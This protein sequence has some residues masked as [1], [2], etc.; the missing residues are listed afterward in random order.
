MNHTHPAPPWIHERLWKDV[1]GPTPSLLP[2]AW[3]TLFTVVLDDTLDRPLRDW[4]E[5]RIRSLA[6][7][8]PFKRLLDFLDGLPQENVEELNAP[9]AGWAQAAI[10]V[11]DRDTIARVVVAMEWVGKNV[12][13]VPVRDDLE[14]LRKMAADYDL[15]A[16]PHLNRVEA[17]AK[18]D[19]NETPAACLEVLSCEL[20]RLQTPGPHGWWS[21]IMYPPTFYPTTEP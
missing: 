4:A 11:T 16:L 9:D 6:V 5:E 3:A 18:R 21:T 2:D 7:E 20:R 15:L 14:S 13:G 19:P 1:C 8:R 10:L 12:E 17:L